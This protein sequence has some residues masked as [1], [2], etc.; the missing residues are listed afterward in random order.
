MTIL[1]PVTLWKDFDDTLPFDDEVLLEWT[2]DGAVVRELA[3]SGRKTASGR[4][5]IHA[6]Y[7]FPEGVESFPAVLVLFEAGLPFDMGLVK[8]LLSWGYAVFCVDYCGENASGHFTRYPADV[9]YANYARAGRHLEYA[10]PTAKETSW[11]EWA[12][13]ARYAARYLKERKEVTKV[14][15]LGLRTGGEVLFKIAPYAP[16]S[17]FIS[18]CAA[19]WLAYRDIAKFANS[20]QRTFDEERHRFIAGIDSQSYAPHVKCPVLLISAVNDKKYNYDRVYDT[21]QQINPAVEKA[22]LFSAHG[23]GLVGSH[24]IDNIK[25]FLDK[26]LRDRAIFVSRPVT[27]GVEEDAKGNLVVRPKF[28]KLGEIKEYGIFYTERATDFKTRDW[29]RVL[30]RVEDLEEGVGVIPFSIYEGTKKALVYAFALYTNG[31]SVTSKIM[32]VNP[33]KKYANSYLKSRVI[34]AS[35]E[36][37]MN[38]FS[39]FRRRARTIADCFAA[40]VKSGVRLEAG[41]GGIQG[42]TADSGLVSYRVSEPGFEPPEGA[43]F[44]FDAYSKEGVKLKVVFY[45]DDEENVSYASEVEI[46]AGGKWKSVMFDAD[47]FKSEVGAPLR[48][49]H[50]TI[51]VAFFGEGSFLIN[52][53]VWL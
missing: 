18:V 43:S 50:G 6:T 7:V 52:N 28:D 17:C 34:Y 32:E 36:D 13:V 42:I 2:Q 25:L 40:G 53:V 4:V 29:T 5:R 23:S 22:F 16:I 12:G 47:D 41:Y 37:S 20:E 15:A 14:G 19:G 45:L 38:G 48:S 11:Y 21:F 44:R 1:T 49:F 9:D 31:F 33:K 46:G 24:S 10:E 35:R 39:V 8:M 26:Y 27:L 51:A 30:G 3:F